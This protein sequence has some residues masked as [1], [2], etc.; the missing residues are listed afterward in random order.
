MQRMTVIV[1]AVLWLATI[2]VAFLE[3]LAPSPVA[4]VASSLDEAEP[5]KPA[6]RNASPSRATVAKMIDTRTTGDA[7]RVQALP[8]KAVRRTSALAKAAPPCEK[9]YT[10]V[11]N[12]TMCR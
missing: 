3:T 5:G 9:V 1:V 8:W 2:L 12:T 7:E 11:D 6:M 10:V 4:A